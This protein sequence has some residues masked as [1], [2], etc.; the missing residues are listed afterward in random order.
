MDLPNIMHRHTT[1]VQLNDVES[2]RTVMKGFAKAFF[3]Y[4]DLIIETAAERQSIDFHRIPKPDFV[5]E[6]IQD[7]QE[8]QEALG[9]AH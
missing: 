2:A 3:N 7:L 4:G 5:K 6:R 8:T 9:H 1:E